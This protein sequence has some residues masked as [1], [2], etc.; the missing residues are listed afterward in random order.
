MPSAVK[1]PEA[2]RKPLRDLAAL[3]GDVRTRLVESFTTGPAVLD[4]EVLIAGGINATGLD[5]GVVRPMVSMLLSMYRAAEGSR[6]TFAEKVVE[7][8]KSVLK[9]EDQGEIDWG[10]L[11][12]DLGAIL[13]CHESLG[14][15]AK[16]LDVRSEYGRLF[17]GARILTDVRPIF[18]ID[19]GRSPLAATIVHTLRLTYHEG[20]DHREFHVALD[21]ADLQQLRELVDRARRKE[22]TLKSEI[23]KTTMTYWAG[24]DS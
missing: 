17:C 14:L 2:H 16:A 20:T 5:P 24:E 22:E 12:N 1:I 19:P 3:S 6:E 4:S 7:A 21:A 23:E 15:A 9:A 13:G 10:S 18:G 8:A 11:S